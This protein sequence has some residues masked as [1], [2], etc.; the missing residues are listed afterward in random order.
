MV[1]IEAGILYVVATPIGNRADM[2]PRAIETLKGVDRI[3]AEDTRRSK[4]LLRDFGIDTPLIPFH[5]HNERRIGPELIGKIASGESIALISDAGTPLVS[6]PGYHLTRAALEAGLRV[7]PIPGPSAPIAGLSVAG[8]PTDRFLFVGFLPP[9]PGQRRKEL[10]RLRELTV[11]LVFFEAPHRI[12]AALVD[13]AQVLGSERRATLCRELTKTFETVH[14]DT[15]AGVCDFVAADPNQRRGEFVLVVEGA[16][17]KSGELDDEAE[18]VAT[19]L[20]DDLPVK[21]AAA[22]TARITG[23]KKNAIYQFLLASG[24]G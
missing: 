18:R 3:A 20:A 21:Q 17:A 15:L 9:K 24:E 6:D 22:L 14:H 7:V 10:E 19:I 11:T 16:P 2:S 23:A 12:E 5:E 4:P 1:S 8:L 13:M